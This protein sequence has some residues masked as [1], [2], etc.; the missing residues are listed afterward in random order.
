LAFLKFRVSDFQ[1]QIPVFDIRARRKAMNRLWIALRAIVYATLFLAAWISLALMCRNLDKYIPFRVPGWL[2]AIGVAVGVAGT[3]VCLTCVGLFVYS[4]LGTPAIFD[5]PKKFVPHGPYKLIRNPMYL[6]YAVGLLGLGLGLASV[7][8]AL[9]A[10]V[11][12]LIT[13]VYVV[14]AEEPGL[15]RRFG[16]E[17]EDYCQAVPR[18]I[19]GITR[20]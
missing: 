2:V 17:Y 6:G 16:Q 20:R 1:F 12:F 10:M 14:L 19:P 13:H 7:A 8:M 3:A 4:G 5:P 11:A 18:W 9:F 15:R